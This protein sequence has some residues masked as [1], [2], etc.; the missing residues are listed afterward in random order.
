MT[1]L[2]IIGTASIDTLHLADGGTHHA[3]GGAGL[4]T[5]LAA[6]SA[7]A[8]VTL[9]APKPAPLAAPFDAAAARLRWIGPSCP[10]DALPRLD[11]AH[12]G[13]G[14]A[15]LL[16]AAWGAEALLTPE[17]L[18]EDLS[19]FD[20]VHIAALS[21]AAKQ[22]AFFDACRARSARRLSIGTYARIAAQETGAVRALL[23]DADAF[24]MNENEAGIIFGDAASA[25]TRADALLCVTR[26]ALGAWAIEGAHRLEIGAPHALE[27]DPTG[28]GDTFCGVTLAL[29]ARGADVSEACAAGCAA[30]SRMIEHPGPGYFWQRAQ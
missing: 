10:P 24:F 28:A 5:A 3:P 12:H 20:F 6:H 13:A 4:Y 29:L 2:L 30:A 27:R 23:A 22:R 14:K 19:A 16:G 7:G 11:I 25:R 15:T 1:A 17:T 21:S 9:L 26:G 18:P 8:A